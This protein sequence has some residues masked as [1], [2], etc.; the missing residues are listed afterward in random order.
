MSEKDENK[1]DVVKGKKKLF[2]GFDFCVLLIFVLI[3][4]FVFFK[5]N[6][7]VGLK[8]NMSDFCFV[9]EAK[10]LDKNFLDDNKI[11]IGDKIYDSVYGSYYGEICDIKNEPAK[12][13][14][15][16]NING[17]YVLSEL[18]DKINLKV[19]IKCRADI[20]ENK[21]CVG[22]REI[23]IGKPMFLKSKGYAIVGYIIDMDV[24]E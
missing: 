4:C 18:E 10:E 9:V 15:D 2:N 17:I 1:K 12:I 22:E 21:I 5:L 24:D 8:N 14:V 7:K 13:I 19:K 11:D 23:R 3:G 16:D 6:K 20:S